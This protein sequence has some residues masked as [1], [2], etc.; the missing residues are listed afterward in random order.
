MEKQTKEN[1]ML[2]QC[3]YF[4]WK[5]KLFIVSSSLLRK[6]V[7]YTYKIWVPWIT[8]AL[9]KHNTSWLIVPEF[10]FLEIWNWILKVTFSQYG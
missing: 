1:M 9:I 3:Y 2:H 4:I 7:V 10:D 5:G 8:D 6:E